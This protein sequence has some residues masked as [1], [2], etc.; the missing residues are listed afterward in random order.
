M[1]VQLKINFAHLYESKAQVQKKRR[2]RIFK[3]DSSR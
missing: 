2:K 3:L 1:P